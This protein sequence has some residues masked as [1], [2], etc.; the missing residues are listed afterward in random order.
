MSIRYRRSMQPNTMKILISLNF[1]LWKNSWKSSKWYFYSVGSHSSN[2]RWFSKAWLKVDS[3]WEINHETRYK[4]FDLEGMSPMVTTVVKGPKLC[5]QSIERTLLP[6]E[7]HHFHNLYVYIP[8]V[9]T[10]RDFTS[11]AHVW[12]TVTFSKNVEQLQHQ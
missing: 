8:Y 5:R 11:C 4:R 6:I 10:W 1:R 3:T 2:L 9:Q 12:H 7:R